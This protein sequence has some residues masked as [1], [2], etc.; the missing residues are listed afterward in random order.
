MKRSF[1]LIG[2]ALTMIVPS[3]AHAAPIPG[4]ET[5]SCAYPANT[6]LPGSTG[7]VLNVPA[8]YDTIQAAVNAARTGDE[9]LI[10]AGTYSDL[11]D[12]PGTHWTGA[13]DGRQYLAQVVVHTPGILIRG[14]SRS[15]TILD[16]T[17]HSS[18]PSKA[19][20]V[21]IL[22][23]VNNVVVE[24]MTVHNYLYHGVYWDNVKGY[25]GRYL[26]AYNEGDYGI[27]AFGSRCGDI[28]YSYGSGNVDSAF[29]IGECFPCDAVIHNVDAEENSLGYSGTNAGGN[30]T[31]RDSVWNNNGIGISPSSLDSEERPPQRGLTIKNNIVDHNNG[32]YVPGTGIQANFWGLGIV[33]PG[34]VGNIV[35]GN[36]VRDNA[37][38]G[39]VL[40]PIPDANVYFPS[41]NTVW[42][43]TVTHDPELY[44]NSYD[45]AQ[46]ATSG[47]NN[48]WADN[49][50]GPNGTMAPPLLTTIWSCDVTAGTWV[51]PPG[52]DPRIEY[53]L[54]ADVAG[55]PAIETGIPGV[56]NIGGDERATSEWRTWPAPSCTV[57][58]AHY[59]A[60]ACEDAPND[61][62]IASWLPSLGLDG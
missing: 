42:G 3:F 32:K 27:F 44:P 55:L 56:G 20:G 28:S 37:I 25:W 29:Y 51:T 1:V 59:H 62:A 23:D 52:G 34:G 5:G 11:N 48:C 43:N 31:I 6:P 36:Q 60:S 26:T 40:A 4:F 50:I 49:N 33:I 15:G 17:S 13:I 14:A 24:N 41:A 18:D 46:G 30:L 45:L 21:G 19:L 7:R 54:V 2:V 16:G 12:G 9:V 10:A 8:D 47:P 22:S 35:A 58:D 57:G 38:V 61:G 53:K 39:I